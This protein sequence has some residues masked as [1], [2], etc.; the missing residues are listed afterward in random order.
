MCNI[1]GSYSSG[2]QTTNRYSRFFQLA[3][4]RVDLF[5]SCKMQQKPDGIKGGKL[6]LAIVDKCYGE[7]ALR[8]S[9]DKVAE[10]MAKKKATT[11]EDIMPYKLYS[12]VFTAKEQET[13]QSWI[14]TISQTMC[15]STMLTDK[16]DEQRWAA[17]AAAAAP[18]R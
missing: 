15:S 5:Y 3:L 12:W 7:V 16:F 18:L 14:H 2:L 11:K 6:P 4:K 9:F 17:A 13:V 1:L 10:A 8:H